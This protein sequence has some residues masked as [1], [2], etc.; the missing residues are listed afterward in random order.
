MTDVT[1][2]IEQWK[3]HLLDLGKQNRLLHY[4]DTKRGSLR[5]VS[6]DLDYIYD[7]LVEQNKTFVFAREAGNNTIQSNRTENEERN[8][9]KLLKEKAKM[10]GEEQG[11]HTLFLAFGFLNWKEEGDSDFSRAPLVLVPVLAKQEELNSPYELSYHTEDCIL[12]PTLCYKLNKDFGIVLP[13]Y[14]QHT[15]IMEYLQE[16]EKS[17]EEFG[18]TVDKESS[19][20]LFTYAKMKL[21]EDIEAH[22]EEIMNHPV[23]RAFAGDHDALPVLD[24]ALIDYNHDAL[25][26]PSDTFQILD[27]DASQ[28]DAILY[29]NKGISFVLQGPPG[30]GKS[31]TITNIITEALARD[32]KVLF[33]SEKMAALEVVYKRL[34]DA[35][36]DEFCLPLHSHKADKKEV[37]DELNETLHMEKEKT[38]KDT[39]YQLDL[40]KEE[41]KQLNQYAIDLHTVCEP[42]HQSIYE[43]NGHLA[44]LY[45]RPNMEFHLDKVE[46]ITDEKLHQ[47]IYLVSEYEKVL[48]KFDLPL[49]EHPWYGSVIDDSGYDRKKEIEKKAAM[50]CEKISVLN[51]TMAAIM[52]EYKIRTTPTLRGAYQL[53]EVLKLSKKAP[54]AESELLTI[55]NIEEALQL[56]KREELKQEEFNSIKKTL[57]KMFEVDYEQVDASEGVALLTETMEQAKALLHVVNFKSN[58]D[59]IASMDN[60][61]KVLFQEKKLLEEAMEAAKKV[62]GVLET[63]TAKTLYGYRDELTLLELLS[64]NP[65]PTI[66]WF[67]VTK[68]KSNYNKMLEVQDT[69]EALN[70]MEADL[71]NE[72]APGILDIDAEEMLYR[73]ECEYVGV[74]RILKKDYRR[75]MELMRSLY[76]DQTTRLEEEDMVTIIRK[77]LAYQ[78]NVIFAEERKDWLKRFLGC[79]YNDGNTD[80]TQV[81]RHLNDFR[82]ILDFYGE[83]AVPQTIR[84]LLIN[85]DVVTEELKEAR[86][87]LSHVITMDH[88]EKLDNIFR[89]GEK[90]GQTNVKEIYDN[91]NSLIEKLTIIS[92]IFGILCIP[93]HSSMPYNDGLQALKKLKRYNTIIEELGEQQVTLK[94]LFKQKYDGLKTNWNHIIKGLVWIKDCK[95]MGDGYKVSEAFMRI[96]MDESYAETL[97]QTSDYLLYLVNDM[98]GLFEWFDSLFN[99]S[100]ADKKLT[101]IQMQLEKMQDND[102]YLEQWCNYLKSKETLKRQGLGEF[103]NEV[104]ELSMN[105]TIIT[106]S[107]LK[108]FYQLWLDQMVPRFETVANFQ[109]DM[110]EET[111]NEFDKL[112]VKQ[113]EIAKLRVRERLLQNIPDMD[114]SFG[115]ND[116]IGILK[117]ELSKKHRMPLRKLFAT[118]PNLLLS[119]KPCFMMSPLTVSLFLAQDKYKFDLVIFDEASQVRPEDAIGAILRGSQVIIAGDIKQ[120]PPTSFFVASKE[121]TSN[122]AVTGEVRPMCESILEEA[123]LVLPER[124]LRWHYR[125]RYESLIAFSNDAIYNH[126]LITFPSTVVNKPNSGVEYYYVEDGV[127]DRGGKKNNPIEARKVVELVLEQA[128]EH[129]ERSLGVITF[130]DAQK[131]EIEHALSEIR[132]ETNEYEEFFDENK[133]EPFFVKNLENVQGDE[134][135]TIIF[136]IAYGKDANGTFNMN[137]GPL[138]KKDGY[139]R[140]NVAI[141]RAKYN[142]KLVG[143]ILP[144]DMNLETIT[145][146]GVKMLHDYMVYAMSGSEQVKGE[147]TMQLAPFE[148]S[149]Y[150]YL[151]SHNYTVERKVGKSGYR[152]DLAVMHPAKPGHYVLGIECDGETYY[153]ARTVRER[154]RLRQTV[155]KDIGWN[156]YRIW[157]TDWIKNPFVEGQKLLEA[158]EHAIA[159]YVEV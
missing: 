33:V 43:V 62:S 97:K 120:L 105:P 54:K 60:L 5:I 115:A 88:L 142:V 106:D 124:T 79:Y 17:V 149:I 84:E 37:L 11:L 24:K 125:S 114:T 148:D 153:A 57:D 70:Q 133:Q 73:F 58:N 141:T 131:Q 146:E 55:A 45:L 128:R 98:E 39:M 32:K 18:W 2:L 136:S 122:D 15:N 138:S 22:K 31:Q 92:Q 59:V 152:I 109:G 150:E 94:R 116:E 25:S 104:E 82:K 26:K 158:V 21:Y 100:L 75:D 74:T 96:C 144:Q 63:E 67:D 107:F 41:R 42:L 119:L 87:T 135:D 127:Y 113:L 30:T 38:Y 123:Q 121:G 3:K 76:L 12:N 16:V 23:L 83:E 112:D 81:Q 34:S 7:Y 154:E 69:L 14:S 78:E 143:S 86:V 44:K 130:S 145:G 71:L 102:S 151:V 101:T 99:A 10:I 47:L 134:R 9:L 157:S 77:V 1:T 46:E 35:G 95:N 89:F 66:Q 28:Q 52:E 56:A 111:R 50:L 13:E 49:Q 117:R 20:S 8:I 140:L 108:R 80:Y 40:L 48:E 159:E 156:I 132:L 139:R 36:L 64:L 27:A 110:L 118:I 147:D 51:D 65:R 6:P 68:W 129:K 19:L 53:L 103:V 4:R 29:S 155:L 72:F 85:G 91:V 93:P 61:L 90:I 137:F 126:N